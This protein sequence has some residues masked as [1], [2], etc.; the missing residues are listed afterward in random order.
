MFIATCKLVPLQ[1]R[2]SLFLWVGWRGHSVHRRD[3]ASTENLKR[4]LWSWGDAAH[5]LMLR[6]PAAPDGSVSCHHS[7]S[8]LVRNSNHLSLQVKSDEGAWLLFQNI[9]R[10]RQG[11]CLVV[12]CSPSVHKAVGLIPGTTK[13][14]NE[15]SHWP[16]GHHNVH[17][18]D[19]PI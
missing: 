2:E 6:S 11:S 14:N 13:I 1:E 12:E 4:N 19:F 5:Q 16:C 7:V 17:Y 8:K 18:Y 15:K 10:V 9:E 3:S